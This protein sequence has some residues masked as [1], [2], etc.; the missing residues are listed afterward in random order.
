MAR[1]FELSRPKQ[2]NEETLSRTSRTFQDF[3][4]NAIGGVVTRASKEP[5]QQ[6]LRVVVGGCFLLQLILPGFGK[7]GCRGS[8]ESVGE[9]C[10]PLDVQAPL[11]WKDR[12]TVELGSGCGLV[13]SAPWLQPCD[14]V[15]EL[16]S[17]QN[18]QEC[19]TDQRRF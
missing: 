11:V 14:G 18:D 9:H 13:S 17:I 5:S 12:Q 19:S 2:L 16:L 7:M 10:V 6:M 1:W 3:M 4:Q 15:V 8:A